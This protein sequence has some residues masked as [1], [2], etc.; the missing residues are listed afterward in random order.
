MTTMSRV[1]GSDMAEEQRGSG[2]AI[3][4]RGSPA[5]LLGHHYLS[6]RSRSTIRHSHAMPTHFF[7]P[8]LEFPV[9]RLTSVLSVIAEWEQGRLSDAPGVKSFV[10]GA[11]PEITTPVA[12]HPLQRHGVA[13]GDQRPA[14]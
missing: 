4:S 2:G 1:L 7:L 11:L 10:G 12:G 14:W 3:A 8:R 9:D 5:S 6:P 13:E